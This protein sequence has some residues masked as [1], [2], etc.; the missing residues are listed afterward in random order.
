MYSALGSCGGGSGH[1]AARYEYDYFCLYDTSLRQ[2]QQP[3]YQTATRYLVRIIFKIMTSL[4]KLKTSR[5]HFWLR[6]GPPQRNQFLRLHARTAT[7]H[8]NDSSDGS[9]IR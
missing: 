1:T 5:I 8:R 7:E 9:S 2:Q 3:Q 6:S 4:R